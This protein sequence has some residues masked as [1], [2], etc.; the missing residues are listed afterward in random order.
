MAL[1]RSLWTPLACA[2]PV[3]VTVLVVSVVILMLELLVANLLVA[4][5]GTFLVVPTAPRRSWA[6]ITRLRWPDQ[7]IFQLSPT[8]S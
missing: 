6:M 7:H 4:I 2:P 3:L 8:S 1:L 5:L